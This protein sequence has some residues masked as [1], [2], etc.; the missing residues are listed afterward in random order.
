MQHVFTEHDVLW[1]LPG[2]IPVRDPA[3]SCV[4]AAA[5]GPWV[6]LVNAIV[7]QAR[8]GGSQ[9][10]SSTTALAAFGQQQREEVQ[11]EREVGVRGRKV[12][13]NMEDSF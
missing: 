9:A 4:Q 5:G 7:M 1:E 2:V 13:C 6:V 11:N 12:A 8:L 10:A 3:R